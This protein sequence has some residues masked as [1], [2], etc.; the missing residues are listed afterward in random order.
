MLFPINF[1]LVRHGESEGNV[2]TRASE[3][4]D[5]SLFTPEF[6]NRHSRNFRLTKNGREQAVSAGGWIR[7][8]ILSKI[9]HIDSYYVS[10]YIRAKETASLL[11]LSNARWRVEFQLRER[12]MALMDNLP[13]NE[14]ELFEVENKQFIQDQFFSIPAG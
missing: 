4:G 14:K 10:D 9:M 5:H 12:D 11:D 3:K 1:I 7:K 13:M 2:A 8:N 6:R